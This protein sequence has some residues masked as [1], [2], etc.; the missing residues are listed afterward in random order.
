MPDT[1]YTIGHSNHPIERL[2]ALLRQH[3]ITAVCDVRS[4]PY[5]RYNPHFDRE[6]LKAALEASGI[7]YVFLGKELGARSDDPACYLYGKVQ[8]TR[9]AQTAL[10]Q[11]G[12]KRV[13]DGMKTYTIALMCA[14]KEPLDCHRT[15]L[16]SRQLAES[17]LRIEHIHEDG[18][19]ESHSDALVRLA[20]SLKLRESQLNFFRSSEDLF[21]D[22]YA[23]QEKRIG[24]DSAAEGRA[25]VEALEGAAG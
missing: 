9:L 14:E 24:Y 11:A 6:A 18:R 2:I 16:V 1:L 10:F 19:L 15:I 7:A 5:S 4:K 21:A 13:R 12:L 3:Q 25:G 23:L 22:A 8:Y 20:H 17:G